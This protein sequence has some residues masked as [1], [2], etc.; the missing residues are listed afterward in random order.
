MV[1]TQYCEYA[2]A[3]LTQCLT[4]IFWMEGPSCKL[5]LS[6]GKLVAAHPLSELL[7]LCTVDDL[8]AWS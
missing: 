2:I 3:S 7:I 1:M 4:L 5:K 6:N 8:K